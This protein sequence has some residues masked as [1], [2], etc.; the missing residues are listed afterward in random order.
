MGKHWILALAAAASLYS[1]GAMADGFGATV[2]AGTLGAGL[3]IATGFGDYF[4]L[5]LNANAFSYNYDGTRESVDYKTKT[6]L[7]TVG[8]LAD[9]YPFGG[10]FRISAGVYNNGNKFDLTGKPSAGSTYTFNG[11]TYDATDVGT[12][13]G[14]IDY[15][16]KIAPYLGIGWGHVGHKSGFNFTADLGVMFT[17]APNVQL[18]GTCSDTAVMAGICDQLQTDLAEEEKK[19][20]KSAD[21]YDMYPVVSIAVGYTF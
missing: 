5:R 14:T 11:T 4:G 3:N 1:A 7:Q 8:L 9:I 13:Q 16:K 18:N 17:G 12:L 20:Q 10:T 2:Q 21:S 19:V 15:D 6:T